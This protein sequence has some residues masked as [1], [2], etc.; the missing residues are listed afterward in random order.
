MVKVWLG[1]ARALASDGNEVTLVVAAPRGPGVAVRQLVVNPRA[2][3]EAVK[4]GAEVRWQDDLGVEDLGLKRESAKGSTVETLVVSH[5]ADPG[6]A[7]LEGARWIVVPRALW[8]HFDEPSFTSSY[9]TLPY[10]AGS[11]DNRLSRRRAD[12]ARIDEAQQSKLTLM[13]VCGPPKPLGRGMLA[14]PV[15]Q[16]RIRLEELS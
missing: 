11:P 6:V 5:R 16:D 4:L 7:V 15:A 3:T 9:A 12:R 10:P 14:R 8:T 2:F 13:E 1:A